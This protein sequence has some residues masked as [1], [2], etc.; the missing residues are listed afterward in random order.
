[1]GSDYVRKNQPIPMSQP[2]ID[3]CDMPD[4]ISVDASEQSIDE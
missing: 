2:G 1:M 3:L 4:H